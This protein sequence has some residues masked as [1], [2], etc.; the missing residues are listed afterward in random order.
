MSGKL[1]GPKYT[2]LPELLVKVEGDDLLRAARAVTF[3]LRTCDRIMPCLQRTRIALTPDGLELGTTDLQNAFR[4]VIQT[5]GREGAGAFTLRQKTLLDL[6]RSTRRGE[7]VTLSTSGN[8]IVFAHGKRRVRCTAETDEDFV[9]LP[10]VTGF[11]PLVLD[12]K[13]F[14]KL[15]QHAQE[16]CSKDD[17]RP[18]LSGVLLDVPAGSTELKMIS[19]DGHRLT[20]VRMD[21]R[22][23]AEKISWLIPLLTTKQFVRILR[24]SRDAQI[25]MGSTARNVL[26]RVGNKSV[27]GLMTDAAFPPWEYVA[28]EVGENELVMQTE[29]LRDALF[30]V[31][32]RGYNVL[33]RLRG[34]GKTMDLSF[35]D[36]RIDEEMQESIPYSG[37]P[38][39]MRFC[40]RYL[41]DAVSSLCDETI[42]VRFSGE[43]SQAQFTSGPLRTIVMPRVG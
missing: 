24:Q 36:D 10:S 9:A 1:I 5:Y 22:A 2:P 38:I 29:H 31:K 21:V 15:L 20:I 35:R 25:T 4:C 30:L 41:N 7:Q 8:R 39:D 13:L 43:R 3:P 11:E 18:H 27:I 33:V 28:K 40:G 14:L 42:R 34:D 16:H 26:L 23:R 37:A 6:A 32:K 12:R 19:T 17:S